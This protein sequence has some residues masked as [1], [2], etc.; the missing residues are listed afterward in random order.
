VSKGDHIRIVVLGTGQMGSGIINLLLQKAGVE[1]VGVYGRRRREQA[2]DAGT[3]IG[4]DR[5]LGVMVSQD[6]DELLARSRPDIAIQTTCSTVSDA[7]PEIRTLLEQGIDVISIAEEMA[8]PAYAEPQIARE[9][10]EL[11]C[12]HDATLIGTGVNPGF[13]LDLLIIAL[14][15][16]CR[17][18]DSIRANRV[19]DLSPYGPT[20]LTSQGVGLTPE[21]FIAGIAS[22]D[23]VGHQGFPES[24]SIIAAAT[25]W[26][27]DRIEQ[28]RDAIVSTVRRETPFVVVEPGCVAG[29]RHTA[30]AY[31][32]GLPV[33]ELI[34]PQ[35]IHPRLGGIETGDYI[36]IEGDP[37]VHMSISP[38]IPGG[39]GTVSMAVNLVPRVLSAMPGLKTMADLPAPA[40]IMGDLRAM[41]GRQ[42]GTPSDA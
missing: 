13:V 6:L 11:A 25:G 33:I 16:V 10:D 35:Q 39:I 20:V 3:A 23:V 34:H 30:T 26:H 42:T 15:G 17:R 32:D 18:I 28:Q 5:P 8:F 24:L 38:E 40:V 4:L 31:V 37:A 29:C 12:G 7:A 2:V 22:G 9:L 19:N 1:I 21:A 27:I 36:D 41:A 14:S